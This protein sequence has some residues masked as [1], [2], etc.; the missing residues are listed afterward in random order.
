MKLSYSTW[1]MQTTPIDE[2]VRHCAALG[3]DGLE[4]TIIPGWPTDAATIEPSRAPAHSARSMTMQG[5]SSAGC[6]AMS[7]LLSGDP[8]RRSGRRG[9]ISHLSRCCRR[10]AETRRAPDRHHNLGRSA[11]RLGRQ[12][13][14]WSEPLGGLSEYAERKL[15]SWSASSPMSAHAL[16]RPDDALWLVDQV[17]SPALDRP[18]RHQSL[19]CPGNPHGGIDRK[20]GAAFDS[21]PMSRMNAD[22]PDHEFLIPGEGEMDYPRYLQLMAGRRIRRAH[23]GGDQPDGAA[24]VQIT[25]RWPRRHSRMTSCLSA[26]E[27][28]RHWARSSR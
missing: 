5:S 15:A 3:F 22:F 17:D 12:E 27:S 28:S 21:I 2:A 8:S 25:M 23:R 16:H 9:S 10:N 26:F 11:S 20:A 6:L 14:S 18:F 1:G 4:L 24:R 7:P 13:T 19:Q